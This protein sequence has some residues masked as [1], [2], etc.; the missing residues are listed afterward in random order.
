MLF[1]SITSIV[2][3]LTNIIQNGPAVAATLVPISLTQSTGT[4]ALNAFNIL[5]AN[6]NFIAAEAVA[7][8]DQNYNPDSFN[9]DQELC[10]RDTGLIIDA[11]SQDILLGGNQKSIEAGLSYWNQGYNYVSNQLTTTTSAINYA[12]DIAL[13]VIANTTVTSITGTFEIGRAHV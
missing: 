1:R 11:V 6:R 9:Y 2:S 10:Y 5:K 4:T 7:Y 8:I 3:T 12:R 13:Q